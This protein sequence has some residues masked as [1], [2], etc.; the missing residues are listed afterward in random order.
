M[1]AIAI[2]AFALLLLAPC[3]SQS[4]TDAETLLPYR[5]TLENGLEIIVVENHNAPLASVLV[6]VR[7]GSFVQAS[8]EQG[9][10]HLCEHVVLHSYG[11]SPMEFGIDAAEREAFFNGVTNNELVAFT[12]LLPSENTK[13]GIQLLERLITKVEFQED[14]LVAA[15]AVLLDELARYQ[16]DPEDALVREVSR[17]LWRE[18]W[19]RHDVLGDSASLMEFDTE[20]LSAHY[21]RYYVP[22]NA[23]LVVTGDVSPSEVFEEARRRFRKWKRGPDPFAGVQHAPME[24]AAGSNAV[25]VARDM[26]DVTVHIEFFGA[27]P[28]GSAEDT[29]A[30]DVLLG[31]LNDPNSAFQQRLVRTGLFSSLESSFQVSSEAGPIVVS[32]KTTTMDAH[33]ALVALVAQLDSLD[34]LTGITADDLSAARKYR[35]VGAYRTREE[36][37]TLAPGIAVWWSGAGLDY[38]MDYH[39]R[40]NAQTLEDLRQFAS[41]YLVAQPKVIGVLGP[42]TAILQIAEW[43][44]SSQPA[45]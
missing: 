29:Y 44:R 45:R 11:D 3:H 21:E 15:R 36:I 27:S 12:L 22:N 19:H 1:L 13:K 9:L 32:G 33:M 35:K 40:M 4:E 23:V 7:S 39:E 18:S 37:A 16:S 43:L 25:L 24:S 41:R 20:T 5:D 28:H 17:Q 2:A 34:Q 6:G 8:G 14:E 10:A 26:Q 42:E 38:Y 30:T 31:L